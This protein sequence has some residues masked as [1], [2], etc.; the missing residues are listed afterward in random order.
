MKCMQE[1][2]AFRQTL[3]PSAKTSNKARHSPAVALE[4]R[5]LRLAANTSDI[6]RDFTAQQVAKC[7]ALAAALDSCEALFEALGCGAHRPKR[8][9]PKAQA[10]ERT[11]VSRGHALAR[12]NKREGEASGR[13]GNMAGDRLVRP[14]V[15]PWRESQRNRGGR[16]AQ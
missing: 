6:R 1:V 16:S 13:I 8:N 10:T 9:Q 7:G 5:V 14:L 12:Q 4:L 11:S 15:R 3:A 2:A